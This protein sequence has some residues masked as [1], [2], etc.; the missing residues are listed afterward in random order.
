VGLG[1]KV[2]RR[3]FSRGFTRV[4][5]V[6]E[7]GRGPLAGP[8][9]AAA[10]L[11]AVDT[12]LIRGVDDSKVLTDRRREKLAAAIC[13]RLPFAVGAASVREIDRLNIRRASALAMKRAIDR[14]GGSADVVIID[15]LR[16]PELG[17]EHDALVDGDAKCFAI[18]CASIVAKTVRD[19]LMK[20]LAARYPAY[21][22]EHNAGYATE[23]HTAAI[24]T[25]GI[26]RH[27]RMSFAP[28]AQRDLFAE[29][30]AGV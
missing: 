12:R 17:C 28:C 11:V 16:L 7:V 27:H 24:T 13:S 9:L 18:A 25:S 23:Q 8:V 10:V 2:E 26:T 6:D 5:G 4:I 14:L 3:Y 19:R 1:F 29:A 22:W 30:A 15:G 21:G 20:N